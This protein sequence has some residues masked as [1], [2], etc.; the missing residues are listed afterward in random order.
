MCL[1]RHVDDSTEGPSWSTV[2]LVEAIGLTNSGNFGEPM[3]CESVDSASEPMGL[4]LMS[5]PWLSL[6]DDL[7]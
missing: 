3:T 2:L 1:P 6:V 7:A 5:D 4:L